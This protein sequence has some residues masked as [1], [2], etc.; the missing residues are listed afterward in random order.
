M[1][2]EPRPKGA[3]PSAQRKGYASARN[4][5]ILDHQSCEARWDLDICRGYATEVHHRQAR[6]TSPT[7]IADPDGFLATCRPC[8]EQIEANPD[9]AERRGLRVRAKK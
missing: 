7:T 9:E 6:S 5:Y 4:L 1:A 3:D 8:H 2:G